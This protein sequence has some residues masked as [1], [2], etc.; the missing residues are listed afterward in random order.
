MKKVKLDTVKNS[1][2][3]TQNGQTSDIRFSMLNRTEDGFKELHYRVMCREYLGDCV[4]FA[5]RNM[6]VPTIYGFSLK[7][8]RAALNETIFSLHFDANTGSRQRVIDNLS[9]IHK[10]ESSMDLKKTVLYD[11]EGVGILENSALVVVGSEVWMSSPF[12]LSMYTWMFR[13]LT[14]PT[15][16]DNIDDHIVELARLNNSTDASTLKNWVIVYKDKITFSQILKN[17]KKILGKNRL[18]GLDDAR[19]LSSP[20]ESSDIINNVDGIDYFVNWYVGFNHNSH[21]L[22]KLFENYSYIVGGTYKKYACKSIGYEWA[23]NLKELI[24]NG[25]NG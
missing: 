4:V 15:T 7:G 2:S 23:N 19:L 9:M 11:V 21:G 16:C 1:P 12:L 17:Y 22:I 18:T 10:V 13:L 3:Y 6:D 14:Y 24:E 5:H 20:E 8:K 25:S